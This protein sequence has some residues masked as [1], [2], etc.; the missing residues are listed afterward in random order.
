VNVTG[1]A[2]ADTDAIVLE[3][4]SG[5]RIVLDVAN[6]ELLPDGH[7]GSAPTSKGPMPP[8]PTVFDRSALSS[9]TV[10]GRCPRRAWGRRRAPCLWNSILLRGSILLRR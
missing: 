3:A 2:V 1:G 4:T 7:P 8:D 10:E 5:L 6:P 9:T